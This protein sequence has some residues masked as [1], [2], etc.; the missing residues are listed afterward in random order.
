MGGPNS[1]KGQTYDRQITAIGSSGEIVGPGG[2]STGPTNAPS[3]LKG[4][5]ISLINNLDSEL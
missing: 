5:I 1:F 4:K 3:G 2:L